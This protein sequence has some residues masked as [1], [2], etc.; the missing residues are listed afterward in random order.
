MLD[1]DAQ[2]RDRRRRDAA[3]S[4][5]GDLARVA[6]DV[7]RRLSNRTDEPLFVRGHRRRESSTRAAT[8]A[9]TR[10]WDEQGEG[11]LAGGRAAA[12]AELSS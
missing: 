8:A 4:A 6:P 12:R 3:S 1:G 7:R 2:P 11:R 5:T 9:P 10:S